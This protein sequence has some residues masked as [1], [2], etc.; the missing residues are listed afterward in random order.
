AVLGAPDG[1]AARLLRTGGEHPFAGTSLDE[2]LAGEPPRHIVLC[3]DGFTEA[4]ADGDSGTGTGPGTYA[5]VR[6]AAARVLDRIREF[7]AAD[8]ADGC[9]LVVLTRL[10]SDTGSGEP[11]GSLAGASVQGLVRSAQ[12]EHPGRIRLVD[13]DDEQASWARLAGTFALADDQLALRDGV[14]LV[15]RLAQAGPPDHRIG[16]PGPGAHR[17]GIP[18]RGTLENLTWVPC[19]EVTAPLT[20]GQV[21]IAVEA[22]GL[23]FRDVTMALG[24]VER[25]A[26]DD[27][28]G[29]EGAGTVLEIADDVTGLAPGDRVTGLFP[30]A[31][32]RVAVADRRL[33]VP[34]PGD[35]SHAEAASVPGAHLTAYYALC[36]LARLRKGQRILVH[37]AA[38]G[39]GMAAVQLARHLGA[40]VYATASPAKWPALRALGLDDEHLA[41]SRDLGFAERFL[42]S[43]GGRGVDVVLNSLAHGFVDASLTLLPRGGDFIEMG[44]TDVRDPGKVAEEHPGVVYR[45]FDLYE[46]G[47]DAIAG[48]LRAVM[49]LF[50]DGRLRLGPVTVHP[51][52][53]ARGAFREMSRGRHTGKIVFDLGSGFGGGTVLV[54][55]G[56]GGVGSLVARHLVAE[57]GVRS[58][59][60]AGRRGP[61]AGGA[62]ELAAELAAA[63]ATVRVVA[64]DVADR[65]AVAELLA[66][67]PPGYPLTAV[68]H[69]AGVLADGTVDSLTGDDLDRVLRVKAGGALHLH[70]LTR[71]RPLSA[72]VLFSALAGTLGTAGQAN[73][74]AANT[75]LDGLAARRR[76][77]G[78]AGTALCWGWWQ[79]PSGMTGQLDPTDLAR[80]R[81]LGIAAM[82]AAEALALF[83]AAC[84]N[85]KPVLVPARLDL[86]VLRN[87][88]GDEVPALLRELADGGRPRRSAPDASGG[89][90]RPGL[91]ER[92]SRLPED[93]AA[94][95]VLDTVRDQAAVVLGHASAASVEPDRAFTHL[96][97]DSLTSVE[98]CNRLASSTGL[99][100]PSTLVFSYPTPRE[101]STY[102]LARLRP[103]P[104]PA[105][106][107][108]EIREILRTVPVARLRSAGLLDQVLACAEPRPDRSPPPPGVPDPDGGATEGVL[109]EL[110]LDALVDLAL[111]ERGE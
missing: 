101:L 59:V 21:R 83:D 94:A 32:G 36:R 30:G 52:R 16:P 99:R 68:V 37:A 60:L 100:L 7:L 47:P 93:E 89:T 56:T 12:R 46:A 70:E 62:R 42:E 50:A 48:M 2:V 5:A 90:G 63:G 106:D 109:A 66:E 86:A 9:T 77:A 81:R 25:T 75:F 57:H 107:D 65:A 96:G 103:E 11:P 87:R 22:A 27:G 18:V 64:C 23:N 29:S 84:A 98:L 85:G 80:V 8:R 51:V 39:V 73:Y 78:L 45:A 67:M 34:V 4:D 110:N 35:W 1:T 28:I 92:V 20:S 79:Q 105:G 33:L 43:S 58:L 31:F 91:P 61:A 15:P 97:F 14:S 102:V 104:G 69:A 10:A 82:P 88:T 74:A 53:D 3:P 26:F 44:K 111:D 76:A 41:S 55:G 54:T 72:F 17:L 108:A 38:G 71:G 40:E 19:P 6:G 13:L 95:A 49:E 24:L